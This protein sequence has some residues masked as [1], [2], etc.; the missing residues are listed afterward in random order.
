M[1][2]GDLAARAILE[3]R[4]AEDGVGWERD[5]GKKRRRAGGSPATRYVSSWKREIGTELA[6][7]RL[8]RRFLFRDRGRIDRVVSRACAYP[9]IAA[10]IVGYASG[11]VPYLEARRRVLTEFPKVGLRFAIAALVGR[12]AGA[13][14]R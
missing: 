4:G 6:D 1:V 8:I 7:S 9:E 2:S 10:L 11:E 14:G 12:L 13:P 3:D 5:G